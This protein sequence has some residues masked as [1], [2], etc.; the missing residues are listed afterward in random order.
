MMVFQFATG[1]Y[2]QALLVNLK[3][4][5]KFFKNDCY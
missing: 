2:Q 4:A 3:P 1:G 5:T